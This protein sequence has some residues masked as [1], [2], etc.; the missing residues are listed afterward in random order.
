MPDASRQRLFSKDPNRLGHRLATQSKLPHRMTLQM[1][2]SRTDIVG[3][4][5]QLGILSTDHSLIRHLVNKVHQRLPIVLAHEDDRKPFELAG[6]DQRD[7]LEELIE[8][9]K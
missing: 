3:K 5:D 7:E 9:V 4:K 6:L 8:G 2:H 1:R